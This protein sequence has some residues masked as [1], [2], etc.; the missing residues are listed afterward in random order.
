[1]EAGCLRSNQDAACAGKRVVAQIGS[2]DGLC[3]LSQQSSSVAEFV[4]AGI[5]A[6]KRVIGG[7]R[8]P[9]I[10][11][12]Q[13][14]RTPISARGILELIE[15][16]D[17]NIESRTGCSPCRKGDRKRRRRRGV[18]SNCGASRYA[19]VYRIGRGNSLVA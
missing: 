2:S 6:G 8:S 9:A 12:G 5:A 19:A 15:H 13:M 18:D 11:V 14:Y 10:G 3:A 4:F 7:E 17:G 16:A 1:M